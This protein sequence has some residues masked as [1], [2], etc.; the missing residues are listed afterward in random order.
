MIG[1]QVRRRDDARTVVACRLAH[2]YRGHSSIVRL[3][4]SSPRRSQQPRR[5]RSMIRHVGNQPLLT[6]NNGCCEAFSGQRICGH[7]G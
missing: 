6:L 1:Y 3:N 4:C 5:W 7:I 2:Q